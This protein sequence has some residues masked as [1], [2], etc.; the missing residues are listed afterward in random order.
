MKAKK[1]QTIS[2]L[3][4]FI[5]KLMLMRMISTIVYKPFFPIN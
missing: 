3:K 4:S 5:V 1:P 2:P